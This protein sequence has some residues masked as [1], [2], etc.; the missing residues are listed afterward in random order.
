[1]AEQ[2]Q[3]A[4]RAKAEALE[5]RRARWTTA[6]EGRTIELNPDSG[7]YAARR[8]G[9]LIL[10]RQDLEDLMDALEAPAQGTA[11]MTDAEARAKEDLERR[12]RHWTIKL[13]SSR[14]WVIRDVDDP[15]P[16]LARHRDIVIAAEVAAGKRQP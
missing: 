8:H 16:P 5:D 15:E 14:R 13:D 6:V 1:M 7:Y 10:M 9:E 11:P 3:A 12:H 4:G 2:A